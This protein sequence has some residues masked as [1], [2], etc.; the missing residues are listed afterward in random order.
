MTCSVYHPIN[1]SSPSPLPVCLSVCL[2]VCLAHS[3]T[4]IDKVVQKKNTGRRTNNQK[5][6][7]CLLPFRYADVNQCLTVFPSLSFSFS[8]HHLSTSPPTT[9]LNSTQSKINSCPI[10]RSNGNGLAGF[11]LARCVALR[12]DKIGWLVGWLVSCMGFG[13]GFALMHGWDGL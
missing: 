11:I 4:C 13:F 5:S 12:C 10:K 7:S 9:Q 3:L 6:R 8:F 1:Q 2:S